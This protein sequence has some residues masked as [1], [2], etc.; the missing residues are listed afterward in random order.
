MKT[1]LRMKFVPVTEEKLEQMSNLKAE[2]YDKISVERIK[3]KRKT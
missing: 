1:T 2:G 3:K